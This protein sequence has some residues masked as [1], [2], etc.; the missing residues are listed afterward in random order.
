MSREASLLPPF[1]SPRDTGRWAVRL[2]LLMIAVAWVAVG[3][4]LSDVWL[5]T[6]ALRGVS[7]Q[8]D[9]RTAQYQ[10]TGWMF[11]IQSSLFVVTSIAFVNWLYQ[12]R[13]NVRA[14][15]M[16]RMRYSRGWCIWGFLTPGLNVVRPYQVVREIW[17]ASSPASLDPFQWKSLP[18]PGLVVLWWSVFLAAAG[19]RLLAL[20]TNLGGDGNLQ[21][22]ALSGALTLVAD[23]A[24]GLAAGLSLFVVTRLS[25][26]QETKW[27]LQRDNPT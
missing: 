23:G 18:A 20:L 4:D 22:L 10:T 8:T 27:A 24:L 3:I 9:M 14:L 6:K 11:W 25:D 19:L 26:A 5:L 16:R 7:V 2:L 12:A 1:I 15:G 13:I 17:K 21:K